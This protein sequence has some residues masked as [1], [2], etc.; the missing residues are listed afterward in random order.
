MQTNFEQPPQAAPMPMSEREAAERFPGTR[1]RVERIYTGLRTRAN[2]L[3]L[4]AQWRNLMVG[5]GGEPITTRLRMLESFETTLIQLRDKLDAQVAENAASQK[6]AAAERHAARD[7]TVTAEAYIVTKNFTTFVNGVTMSFR[8]GVL[9]SDRNLLIGLLANNAPLV[10]VDPDHILTCPYC[11]GNFEDDKR[12][13]RENNDAVAQG[14]V[15]R[16]E[17]APS[18]GGQGRSAR[19]S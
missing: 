5:L 13:E 12:K 7:S 16:F 2:T 9:I 17:A 6:R 11:R 18:R 3:T 10:G 4:D 8:A 1:E 19:K 14:N 15:E